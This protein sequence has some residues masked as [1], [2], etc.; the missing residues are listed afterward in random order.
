MAEMAR[1]NNGPTTVEAYK[2]AP[3]P[4]N[5]PSLEVARAVWTLLEP[6]LEPVGRLGKKK[7]ANDRPRELADV[8]G[9]LLRWLAPGERGDFEL[10]AMQAFAVAVEVA[11]SAARE[12]HAL[13]IN[14]VFA[15]LAYRWS[16]LY[17]STPGTSVWSGQKKDTTLIDARREMLEA[18]VDFARVWGAMSGG[19]DGL[20]RVDLIGGKGHAEGRTAMLIKG[21]L[22]E[23]YERIHAGTPRPLGRNRIL[24]AD[25]PMPPLK[26][27]KWT[28][29]EKDY[30]VIH[31]GERTR[32]V[33]D[34]LQGAR[35][36]LVVDE[37]KKDVE[38]LR[39][40]VRGHAWLKKLEE[41]RRRGSVLPG[42]TATQ[43]ST[44]RTGSGSSKGT[45]SCATNTTR[46]S[47]AYSRPRLSPARSRCTATA[48]TSTGTSRSKLRTTKLGTCVSSRATCGRARSRRRTTPTC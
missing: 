18:G 7:S 22:F 3:P 30:D 4:V 11:V 15:A 31:V 27:A 12:E 40:L 8:A 1:R 13:F 2:A 5:A 6:H 47:G 23:A 48:S 16:P 25:D 45:V 26:I 32:E 28:V 24:L 43:R 14:D 42:R 34:L 9:A 10:T 44:R 19:I 17:R 36:F 20:Y 46:W 39:E 35:V 33:I 38:R 37:V 21:E 41:W 29:A